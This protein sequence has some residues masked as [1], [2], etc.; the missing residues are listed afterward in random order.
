MTRTY[1][2]A[3]DGIIVTSWLSVCVSVRFNENTFAEHNEELNFT[4]ISR[5]INKDPSTVFKELRRHRTLK[6]HK[7]KHL[8]PPL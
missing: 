8:P 6:K 2:D 5:K 1:S 4:A 3:N 7:H